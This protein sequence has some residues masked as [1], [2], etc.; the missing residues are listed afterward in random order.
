M[1]GKEIQYDGEISIIWVLI[2]LW[3]KT[4]LHLP[5][6]LSAFLEM[7]SAFLEMVRTL[8]FGPINGLGMKPNVV[9]MGVWNENIWSWN[10]HFIEN[11]EVYGI[12]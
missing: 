4:S 11:S 5:I 8:D 12:D 3:I 10:I 9:D 7:V 6:T 2:L 1:G